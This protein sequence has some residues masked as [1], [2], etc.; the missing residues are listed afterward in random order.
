MLT[1][2]M[3]T[4]CKINI[5]EAKFMDSYDF[6]TRRYGVTNDPEKN[7]RIQKI[8]SLVGSGQTVL[9]LG[10]RDGVLGEKLISNKNIV[11]GMDASERALKL[12]EEKGIKVKLCDLEKEFDLP[13]DFFDVV[14]A[15]E[16]IEHIYNIDKFLSEIY[17]VLKPEGILVLSTPNLA[18]FGRRL[19]LFLNKNPHIE[20]SFTG[21][22]AGHIRYFIKSTLYRILEEHKFSVCYFTSDV[23]NFTASGKFNIR[24]VADII[25]T[26]GKSLIVKAKKLSC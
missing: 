15:G 25:P 7:R 9:D 20:I 18:A 3:I 6:N 2:Q 16:I 24:F 11:H 23:I 12:A 26:L 19:L 5:V 1:W 14:T 17:R 10:C 13:G 4:I 8:V 21:D 22:A